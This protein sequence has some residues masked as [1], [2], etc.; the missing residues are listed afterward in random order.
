MPTVQSD[1]VSVASKG[2]FMDKLGLRARA[3]MHAK[4]IQAVNPQ[5]E[6]TILD[7]GASANPEFIASNY[8]EQMCPTLKITAVGL[9]EENAIWQK[10][11]P[12]IP[13][14]HGSALDLPFEDKSF[15][16]VYSHAVIEHVGSF[17]NQIKM[18][19]EAI[20]V[21]RQS[22]W[23]TTPYRWHPVEFHTVL[24]FLHWL[25]KSMHRYCLKKL[26]L[27]YFSSEESLNLLDGKSLQQ[28]VQTAHAKSI[29]KLP[30]VNIYKTKFLGFSANLLLHIHLKT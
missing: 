10:L 26:G 15:D 20:R 17:E 1:E 3:N 2:G 8:L 4:F 28:A 9:G 12:S 6:N 25:P 5:A 19:R 21:A 23:I 29:A 13:Y 18:I 27:D 22:V 11:Y 7:V 24:P 30:G 14:K 16:I